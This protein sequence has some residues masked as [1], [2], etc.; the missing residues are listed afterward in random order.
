MWHLKAPAPSQAR[1]AH[2]VNSNPL[3]TLELLCVGSLTSPLLLLLLSSSSSSS[4]A[5]QVNIMCMCVYM[6]L[7]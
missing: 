2:A 4:D 5:A 3:A 7:H 1:T 6:R